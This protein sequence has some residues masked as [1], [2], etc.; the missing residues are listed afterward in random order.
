MRATEFV[1]ENTTSFNDDD[2]Y[3][4]NPDTKTIVKQHSPRAF[5]MPFSGGQVRLPNGNI[6]VKGLRAKYMD[7]NSNK[8]S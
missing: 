4:I 6:A 8:S 2:W 7:L 1:M 3:E 5:T